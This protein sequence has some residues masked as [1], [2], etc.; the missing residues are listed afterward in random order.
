M[1]TT[2]DKAKIEEYLD[3]VKIAQS[4]EY[5]YDNGNMSLDEY[6]GYV[7]EVSRLANENGITRE[8]IQQYHNEKHKP[9]RVSSVEEGVQ[10][11]EAFFIK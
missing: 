6:Y 2:E 4:A 9:I 8:L 10:A 11:L 7:E 1:L 5:D 3:Y